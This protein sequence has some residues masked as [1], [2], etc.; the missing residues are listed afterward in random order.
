MSEDSTI[1]QKMKYYGLFCD[2]NKEIER[3]WILLRKITKYGKLL[4]FA[5]GL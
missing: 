5:F 1:R 2:K 3:L 4:T